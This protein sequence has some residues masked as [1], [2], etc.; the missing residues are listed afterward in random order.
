MTRAATPTAYIPHDLDNPELAT[1][2]PHPH[3]ARIRLPPAFARA[4]LDHLAD[5]FGGLTY[6]VGP[7]RRPDGS[8]VPPGHW[9]L[10]GD[11]R[12]FLA[13]AFAPDRVSEYWEDVQGNPI[14]TYRFH[15]IVVRT[16]VV[17]YILRAL[18]AVKPER[19]GPDG[20]P[21][22]LFPPR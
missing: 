2:E 18:E 5:R 4:T 22:P 1:V 17:P 7:A 6:L 14:Y 20:A 16:R 12:V 11:L 10:A 21:V 3:G 13:I 9:A 19:L 8:E 15:E